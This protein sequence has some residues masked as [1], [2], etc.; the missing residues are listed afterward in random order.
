M[1]EKR[2]SAPHGRIAS[3]GLALPC[4]SSIAKLFKYRTGIRL[5]QLV[6]AS[7][8]HPEFGRFKALSLSFGG[9]PMYTRELQEDLLLQE[10][11]A[12]TS[13]E[14]RQDIGL[15]GFIQVRHDGNQLWHSILRQSQRIPLARDWCLVGLI[16]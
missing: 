9:F 11:I 15:F 3:L 12:G 1:G 5:S 16:C 2:L 14:D 10:S 7:L 6:F 8:R 13:T 4:A